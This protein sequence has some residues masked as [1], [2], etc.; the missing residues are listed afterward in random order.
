MRANIEVSPFIK[1]KAEQLN[2]TG[3]DAVLVEEVTTRGILLEQENK[4]LREDLERAHSLDRKNF[5]SGLGKS[6]GYAVLISLAI[7]AFGAMINGIGNITAKE[8]VRADTYNEAVV[9]TIAFVESKYRGIPIEN[10]RIELLQDPNI[11]DKDAWVSSNSGRYSSREDV[12]KKYEGI[13]S[14]PVYRIFINNQ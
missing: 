8:K 1:M 11:I 5:F 12:I 7:I 13:V 2:W 10:V 9:K 6:I 3:Y 14:K 4:S